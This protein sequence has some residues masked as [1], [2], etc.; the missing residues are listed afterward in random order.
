MGTSP[1]A[2]RIACASA[3]VVSIVVMVACGSNPA[4]PSATVPQ[5][6][7][8]AT[9]TSTVLS[10]TSD[11]R[12]FVGL[13]ES[14]A[15]TLQNAVFQP[16]A[17]RS[18]RQVSV[19]VRPNNEPPQATWAL[20]IIAPVGQQVTPGSYDTT[21]F[22]TSTTWALDFTGNGHG[23]NTATGHMVIH[24]VEFGPDLLTLK[25]LRV[26]FENHCENRSPALRGEVAVLA[27]PW[28]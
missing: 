19:A 8:A 18:G 22:G 16:G 17:G 4:G 7:S 6:Q 5:P 14:R 26:S 15:Y 2:L 1:R 24:S 23:C 11:P 9:F 12:D 20:I 10:F 28:R 13:G 25:H 21:N 27:D 3:A